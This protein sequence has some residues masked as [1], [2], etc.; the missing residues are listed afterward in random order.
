[1]CSVVCRNVLFFK[2]LM[3][4]KGCKIETPILENKVGKL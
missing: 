2:L 3:E 1:M 4:C